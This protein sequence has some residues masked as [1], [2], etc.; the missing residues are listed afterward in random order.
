MNDEKRSLFI[1]ID[2]TNMHILRNKIVLPD[3]INSIFLEN[4]FFPIKKVNF[5]EN[6]I[7]VIKFLQGDIDGLLVKVKSIKYI[8]NQSIT[9]SFF[10]LN[11][12]KIVKRFKYN[13][14]EKVIVEQ[15]EFTPIKN[16]TKENNRLA[17]RQ[18]FKIFKQQ[19]IMKL[20]R[21][22]NR[23]NHFL[24]MKMKMK[25]MMKNYHFHLI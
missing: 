2:Y 18:V 12:V 23:N 1:L 7:I 13:D 9:L 15:I 17:L 14:Y 10:P 11:Y 16:K 6:Q 3:T 21:S 8:N 25:M 19:I 24:L 4:D 5:K 22:Q 20:N